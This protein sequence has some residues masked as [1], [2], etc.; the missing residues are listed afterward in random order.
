MK[1]L[2][3]GKGISQYLGPFDFKNWIEIGNFVNDSEVN[4]LKFSLNQ[5]IEKKCGFRHKRMFWVE[6]KLVHD[7]RTTWYTWN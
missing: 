1:L 7:A 4:E 2:M 6:K 5:V 3:D